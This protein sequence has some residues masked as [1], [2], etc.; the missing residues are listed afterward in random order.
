MFS[1]KE[2]DTTNA[3]KNKEPVS[4]IKIFAGCKLKIKNPSIEPKIDELKKVIALLFS[5]NNPTKTNKM[6][7]L[8]VKEDA[9]PSKPSLRFTALTKPHRIKKSSLGGSQPP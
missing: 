1:K 9:S 7:T 3:P 5:M 6:P 8:N 2:N 4:P